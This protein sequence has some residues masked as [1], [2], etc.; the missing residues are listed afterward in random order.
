MTGPDGV[1]VLVWIGVIL[2]PIVCLLLIRRLLRSRRIFLGWSLAAV[3]ALGWA[4]GVWGFLIEPA[5]L[6]VRH[7]TVESPA[8]RG[9]PLRIGIISDTHVAAPHT[10][11]KR[12]H[13]LVER[14]NAEHPDVV[15]LLGDYVGGHEPAATRPLAERSEIL[16]GVEAFRDLRSPLGSWGVLGNHDSWYD[17]AAVADAM[18]RGRVRLLENDAVRVERPG[19]AFWIGGLADMYSSR[20]P[21]LVGGTLRQVTDGAPTVLITHWPDPFADTPSSVALTLAGHTHCGQVNLPVFGRLVHASPG[22]ER[23]PCGLYDEGGRKLFVTGGVGVSILP[24]RFRAPPEIV[25]VTLRA[26]GG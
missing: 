7:V 3:A 11:V 12:I 6:T 18:A 14:M 21:P 9:E 5:T 23:W 1:L 22:S 8:W 2:G 24:V 17:D 20:E 25:I 10:D 26:P 4:C 13:R 15:F 19:G 16:H